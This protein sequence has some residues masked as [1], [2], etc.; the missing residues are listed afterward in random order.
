MKYIFSTFNKE[1]IVC[2]NARGPALA[3]EKIDK[4]IKLNE[5]FFTQDKRTYLCKKVDEYLVD[6]FTVFELKT[7]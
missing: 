3:A 7:T 6:E 2:A 4:I 5:F 1:I